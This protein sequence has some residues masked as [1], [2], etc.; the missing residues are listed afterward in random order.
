MSAMDLSGTYFSPCEGGPHSLAPTG[1]QLFLNVTSGYSGTCAILLLLKDSA[2][3]VAQP[4]CVVVPMWIML[5]PPVWNFSHHCTLTAFTL[6]KQDTDTFWLKQAFGKNKHAT[7]FER[8]TCSQQ[9]RENTG[10]IYLFHIYFSLS[11]MHT[12]KMSTSNWFARQVQHAFQEP[13]EN[14]QRVGE[15]THTAF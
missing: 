6:G 14:Q 4:V 9:P 8:V 13:P 10:N 15:R 11:L 5:G 12:S 2:C 1:A 7:L 3:F